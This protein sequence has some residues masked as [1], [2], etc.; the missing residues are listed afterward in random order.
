M[1]T[2]AQFQ[3]HYR[4][5]NDD[6]LAHIALTRE[7]VP[8]A[9]AALSAELATR[10]ITDLSARR[11]EVHREVAAVERVRQTHI[12][13]ISAISRIATRFLYAAGALMLLYGVFRVFVKAPS[14]Q[15]DTIMIV[16]GPLIIFCAWVRTKLAKVWYEKIL[17]RKPPV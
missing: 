13:R 2:Y 16:I 17:F 5:L 6:E 10:G 8:D 9:A 4:R 14:G 3:E 15:D 11:D 12:E 7:L 1:S